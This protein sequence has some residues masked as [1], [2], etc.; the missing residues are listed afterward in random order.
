LKALIQEKFALNGKAF[1]TE[2]EMGQWVMVEL[3]DG[4]HGSCE[5][6]RPVTISDI[7]RLWRLFQY[8]RRPSWTVTLLWSRAPTL[9]V[10]VE[11][12][13]TR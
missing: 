1:Q 13:S 5:R 8:T 4:S 3:C 6:W 12:Y 2:L 9:Y 11:K 7:S 10:K